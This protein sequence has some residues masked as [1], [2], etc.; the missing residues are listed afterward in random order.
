[1]NAPSDPA[2]TKVIV[3]RRKWYRLRAPELWRYRYLMWVFFLRD[4]KASYKQTILGPAWLVI[5]PLL[6]TGVFTVIFGNIAGLSTDG[7]PHVLFYMSGLVVWGFFSNCVTVNANVFLT[8]V[9]LFSK[10]Y[11]PRLVV[12]FANVMSTGFASGVQFVMLLGFLA[13]FHFYH[14]FEGTNGSILILPVLVVAIAMLALGVSTV[15]AAATVMYRDLSFLVVL[16]MQLWMYSSTV[17]YP[18]SSV[19][20]KYR[21]FMLLNPMVPVIEAFRY[22]FLGRGFLDFGWLCY[23]LA[24]GAVSFFVG[25]V[26]FN[27]AEQ[28]AMDTV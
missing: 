12:P 3:P 22:G 17:I 28:T 18:L 6:S 23:S 14:G 13:Y 15:I 20:E 7:I 26:I 11:F 16:G 2:W 1:M 27:I 4:L 24:F 25:V 8:N 19:P 21:V 9:N 10:V 5:P